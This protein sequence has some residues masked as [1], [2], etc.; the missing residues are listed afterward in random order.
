MDY[1][2]HVNVFQG[3]GEVNLPEPQGIAATWHFI[4]A[5]S[6]NTLPGAAV[7]F[8]KFSCCAYSGG[9]SSGYGN[10][11]VNCGGP[12]P[13]FCEGNRIKG[14]S[15]IHNSG[16]GALGLYWNYCLTTPFFG[17]LSGIEALNH[18]ASEDAQPGYYRA[19]IEENDIACETVVT[20]KIALHRY[21]FPKAGGRLALTLSANGLDA[22]MPETT[23]K[24]EFAELALADNVIAAEIGMEGLRLFVY[25]EASGELAAAS[26]WVNHKEVRETALVFDVC[27]EPFGVVFSSAAQECTLELRLGIST[28]DLATAKRQVREELRS[29]DEIR[30]SNYALW[31]QYLGA[32]EIET[33]DAQEKE[34]FY[35]NFYHT[36]VKPCDWSGESCFYEG[37][38]FV[39]DFVTLWDQYK[40]QLPLIFSLYPEISHKIVETFL[41]FV[42][43]RSILPH[44]ICLT[45]NLN[46]EAKQARMLAVFVLIDAFLRDPAGYDQEKLLSAMLKE[47]HRAE[48][49]DFREKGVCE[50]TTHT[51]D[52]AEACRCIALFAENMG[53]AALA[54]EMNAFAQN[55]KKCFDNET[56][57]LLAESDYYEGNHWNY[58]FRPMHSMQ[59]RIAFCGGRETFAALLDRFFGYT[60]EDDTATRFEGF[61]NETDMEAPYAYAYAGR[62]DR[63]CEV[64]DAGNRYMF[65]AGRGGL[66]GN[67]DSGGL[68]SCYLW[69]VLGLFPVSGQD[70]MLLGVPRFER[71]VMHL[72]SGKD[73]IIERQGSG[74]Y[75]RQAILDGEPLP[76]CM[77]PASRIMQG[78]TLVFSCTQKKRDDEHGTK[79]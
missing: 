41:N 75:V 51:L 36:L 45:A 27:P 25:A 61:N 38:A 31:N 65:T 48:F 50:K 43:S 24:P 6:G 74:I 22:S 78:G 66:P 28:K 59:E 34:I 69:N 19:L 20:E 72:A 7:P 63:L 46:I 62:H 73:L 1:C 58:S 70:L 79:A 3:Q 8:G 57:L 21:T 12:V 56:G 39:I 26:L 33:P 42:C 60:H 29:F 47:F 2:S 14:L 5:L 40:T 10:H 4:K 9:Y 52:M 37:D 71:A 18:I 32:I 35:S 15:H 30:E 64:I 49:A 55:W 76:D 16:T 68:S 23:H 54:A 11:A 13:K 67:N 17:S 44:T 77:V 53:K